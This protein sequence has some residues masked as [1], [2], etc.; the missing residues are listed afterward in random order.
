MSPKQWIGDESVHVITEPPN[1]DAH[2]VILAPI[3]LPDKWRKLLNIT[4]IPYKP[5]A[6]HPASPAS[7][8]VH[9]LS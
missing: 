3:Q 2:A 1:G 6:N 4:R 7:L 8:P 9:P 5:I